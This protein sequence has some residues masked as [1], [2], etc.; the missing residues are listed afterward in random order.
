MNTLVVLIGKDVEDAAVENLEANEVQVHGVKILGQI[1]ELPDF[2]GVKTRCFDDGFMPVLAVEQHEHR[3]ADLVAVFVEGDRAGGYGG[4]FGDAVDG[5]EVG[6]N[7]VDM[8]NGMLLGRLGRR[9]LR[10]NAELEDL[11]GTVDEM[12][13]L[14]GGLGEV[15]EEVGALGGGKV[16]ASEPNRRGKQSLIGADLVEGLVIGEGQGKESTIGSIEKTKAVEARFYLEVG[17][18]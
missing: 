5:A 3:V 2:G 11:K 17:S 4:G 7:G 10:C 6:G 15:D 12:E 18:Y 13:V 9:G 8:R 16:E 14:A 1:D